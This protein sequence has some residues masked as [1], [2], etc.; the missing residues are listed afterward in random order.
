[1]VTYHRH[2]LH[3]HNNDRIPSHSF[4]FSLF[5]FIL[6]TFVASLIRKISEEIDFLIWIHALRASLRHTLFP[7][8]FYSKT[9]PS[10]G[11]QIAIAVVI[12]VSQLIPGGD[13]LCDCSHFHGIVRPILTL[14][15]LCKYL[16]V[17]DSAH[18][19]HRTTY[20]GNKK[21]QQQERKRKNGGKK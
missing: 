16:Q 11:Y 1:M 14:I 8:V 6:F 5:L 10:N 21:S 12:I 3:R 4:S 18:R 20:T 19:M 13:E 2:I 15:Q 9:I 17:R 7:S